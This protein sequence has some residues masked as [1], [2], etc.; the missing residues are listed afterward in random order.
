MI[1]VYLKGFRSH[2]ESSYSFPASGSVCIRGPNGSGKTDIYRAIRWALFPKK[3]ENVHPL[4]T[5]TKKTSSNVEVLLKIPGVISV[6]RTATPNTIEVKVGKKRLFGNDAENLIESFLGG[7]KAWSICSHLDSNKHPFIAASGTQKIDIINCVVGGD[8]S[9]KASITNKLNE[10][11]AAMKTSFT[12]YD[13]RKLQHKAVYG[14]SFSEIGNDIL[15]DEE[16]NE[17]K[18]NLESI[19][20]ELKQMEK[21]F[22]KLSELLSRES[23]LAKL[24]FVEYTKEKLKELSDKKDAYLL[25][26]SV[27]ANYNKVKAS[28]PKALCQTYTDDEILAVAAQQKAYDENLA[29][30]KRVGV[31]YNEKDVAKLVEQCT[32]Q[33]DNLSVIEKISEH[34]KAQEYLEECLWKLPDVKNASDIVE[35]QTSVRNLLAQLERDAKYTNLFESHAKLDDL[36]ERLSE[37]LKNIPSVNVKEYIIHLH[38]S[39]DNRPIVDQRKVYED[40]CLE[41]YSEIKDPSSVLKDAELIR[42]QIKEIN[43]SKVALK[44]PHCE[45]LVRIMKDNIEV[46]TGKIVT[47]DL[48][49]LNKKLKKLDALACMK[50]PNIPEGDINTADKVSKLKEQ[51]IAAEEA[52]MLQMS[53]NEYSTLEELPDDVGYV[54]RSK[55]ST[56][57]KR[58]KDLIALYDKAIQAADS[59]TAL[60]KCPDLPSSVSN[61]PDPKLVINTLKDLAYVEQ[62]KQDVV[63]MKSCNY[64]FEAK[65]DLD[66]VTKVDEVTNKQVLDYA[67]KLGLYTSS[68]QELL[69][70]RDKKEGI[71]A[72]KEDI[73][74]LKD[75]IAKETK[76][77]EA[78]SFDVKRKE[79]YMQ[80]KSL[81][82]L[83]TKDKTRYDNICEFKELVEYETKQIMLKFV[84]GLESNVN[85]FLSDIGSSISICIQYTDKIKLVCFNNEVKVGKP[86]QLSCGEQSL[87]SFAM[88]VAFSIQSPSPILILDEITDKLSAENKDKAIELLLE[89]LEGVK[90][91]L[92][93]TDH[94]CHCGDYNLVVELQKEDAK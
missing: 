70:V 88:S 93:I 85:S 83:Y 10:S 31:S 80:L 65:K 59:V 18:K 55:Y 86:D 32:I 73:V 69:D 41:I 25:Y 36:K 19:T 26:S 42:Q 61:H 78:H 56:E 60:G 45:G 27:L 5:S 90:K 62:P 39:I 64:L 15:S 33:L 30:C 79:S 3:G 22:A 6:L 16:F 4:E 23:A 11:K 13:R 35:K 24:T 71:K 89:K 21:D 54:S 67:S 46:Y 28:Y 77:I 29:K 72:T 92:L 9:I 49:S 66:S 14:S 51:L 76:K 84:T 47:G 63:F 38:K 57:T 12:A 81:K 34:K 40:K 82:S 7:R 68:L 44:C 17:C 43:M 94:N 91:C 8:E 48:D 2:E 87:V 58:L 53:I 1:D 37:S 50:Y 75:Q 20:A 74:N 52:M